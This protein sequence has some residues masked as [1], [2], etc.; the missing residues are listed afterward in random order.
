M[1]PKTVA[2]SSAVLMFG[3]KA[4]HMCL[5]SI[6]MAFLTCQAIESDEGTYFNNKS[7]GETTWTHPWGI[8]GGGE[9]RSMHCFLVE[10]FSP[11]RS[12]WGTFLKNKP[13]KGEEPTIFGQ[14]TFLCMQRLQN[15]CGQTHSSKVVL[16][17]LLL[18]NLGRI[19]EEIWLLN[20][21]RKLR[22]NKHL[23]DLSA[24][25]LR[26]LALKPKERWQAWAG[27]ATIFECTEHG[28]KTIAGSLPNKRSKGL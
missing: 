1:C 7:N 12:I 24:L 10:M 20:T 13:I 11:A 27:A 19:Q 8:P 6:A 25:A 14:A 28:R 17:S 22:L 9:G 3:A 18:P 4:T 16:T 15:E 5:R 2:T 26:C 21:Y 23:E